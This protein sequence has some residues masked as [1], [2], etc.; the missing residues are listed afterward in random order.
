MVGISGSQHL[1]T[2]WEEDGLKSKKAMYPCIT[3]KPVVE[4]GFK[5]NFNKPTGERSIGKS[6]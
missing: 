2:V 4:K 6:E 1:Y 5:E 3:P